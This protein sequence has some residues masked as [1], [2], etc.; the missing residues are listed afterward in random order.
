MRASVL[1][2]VLGCS[3]ADHAQPPPP[4]PATVA[5]P[6]KEA[7]LAT[8]TLTDEATKR[9]GIET[10]TVV[11]KPIARTR[12]YPARIEAVPGS[13]AMIASPVAGQLVDGA[14]PSPGTQVT[15]GQV[16]LRIKPLVAAEPD[17]M[18]RGQRD[19]AVA[20]AKVDAAKQRADRLVALAR[21]GAASQKASEDAA[22]ELRVAQADLAEANARSS[23]VQTSPFVADLALPLRAPDAGTV[24]R[25]LVA[26]GQ[27]VAA[28]T[29][30]IELAR[31]DRAWVRVAVYAGDRDHLARTPGTV[32]ALGGRETRDIA[33]SE[34]P[35]IADSASSTIELVYVVDNAGA[36]FLPGQRVLATLPLAGEATATV[37]PLA[38]V[39][40][41]VHGGTW[42]YTADKPHTFTRRRIEVRDVL[43]NE[44]VVERGPEPGVAIVTAGVA[45]LYGSEFG[46]K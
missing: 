31:I 26:P 2:I 41:D 24:L 3:T 43:G 10:T 21:S 32:Q 25:L 17:L 13:S 28:G 30:L 27:V 29:S 6:V 38:A 44:V 7:E 12:R 33:P 34:A 35:A 14:V 36:A 39:V 18:A 42:I 11:R 16:L 45:E 40:Y 37:V 4:P 15:R 22:A 8:V 19:V 46:S 5:S 9:L 1:V 20:R 23:R